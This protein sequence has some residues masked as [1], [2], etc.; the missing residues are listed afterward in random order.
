[1]GEIWEGN[2]IRRICKNSKICLQGPS[3]SHVGRVMEHKIQVSRVGASEIQKQVRIVEL[4][5]IH[6]RGKALQK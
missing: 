3:L 5:K 4:T 6:T 1:M 2:A